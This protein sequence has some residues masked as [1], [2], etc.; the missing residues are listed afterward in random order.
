M[1]LT[2]DLMMK[3]D[4]AEVHA[5]DEANNAWDAWKPEMFRK[6][7]KSKGVAE[8]VTDSETGELLGFYVWQLGKKKIFLHKFEVSAKARAENVHKSM[9]A[10]LLRKCKKGEREVIELMTPDTNEH[11]KQHLFLKESGFFANNV[12]NFYGYD[13]YGNANDGYCWKM[14]MK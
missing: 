5:L 14:S 6:H 7:S 9:L 13:D 12:R 10:R 2:Y 1:E 3:K 4:M 11:L 8:I